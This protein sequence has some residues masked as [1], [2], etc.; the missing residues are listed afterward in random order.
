MVLASEKCFHPDWIQLEEIDMTAATWRFGKELLG[1]IWRWF[2]LHPNWT[3]TLVVLAA[4]VPF[5][6]KPFNIDEPMFVWAARQIH[7]H[8]VNPYGFEANW[9]GEAMPMWKNLWDPPLACYYLATAAALCGWSEVALHAAFL[10][11]ALAA[12]LG[13]YRLARHFCDHPMLAALVTLFTPVFLVSSTTVMCDVPMLAFWV[14]ATVLWVEGMERDSFWRLAGSALLVSLATMTKHFGVSLI[15]L[16]AVYSLI[17]KRQSAR[18][19]FCLLI[20]LATLLLYQWITDVLYGQGLLFNAGS[21]ATNYREAHGHSALIV[22]LTSLTFTGGCL[23]SAVLFA[24]LLWRARVLAVF[25]TGT[26]LMVTALFVN[27]AIFKRFPLIQDASRPWVEVQIVFWAIGG[28]CVLALAVADALHGCNPRSWLLVLWVSGTLL[29]TSLFNWDVNG[30][31]ILPMA[32]AVGIL[33]AR[34]LERNASTTEKTRACALPVCLTVGALLALLVARA[35]FLLATA[36]RLS[37]QQTCA[38]YA[39]QQGTLWFQGHWGF[40][41]YME[42]FGASALDFAR[43]PLKPGDA[44]AVPVNNTNLLP[45]KPPMIRSQEILAVSGP[46][47][48]T[49][50]SETAGAGFYAAVWGPLPFVFGRIPL[51]GVSVSVLRPLAPVSSQ[52]PQ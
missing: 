11:P 28:V 29:F 40:Q 18:W 42:A 25:A 30:R 39:H 21:H 48:L 31:S 16:L 43:S 2:A 36:V 22:G 13:T 49:T 45:P 34:R 37:A 8:P 33:L 24:P 10:L 12:I 27:G 7:A 52:S 3:L 23:A 32:P 20:P 51:E 35:D 47:L 26:I 19:A 15:P 5:L 1:K 50:M 6:T 9:Y 38:R 14:W 46:Y 4:L 17:S 41:Y 44:L